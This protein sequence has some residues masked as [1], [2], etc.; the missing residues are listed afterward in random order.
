MNH[1]INLKP[2]DDTLKEYFELMK[3]NLLPKNSKYKHIVATIHII[4]IV[5]VSLFV[6]F[7]LLLPPRLQIYVIAA[8]VLLLLS[9]IVFGKCVLIILTNWIGDTDYDFFFPF[10]QHT[11]YVIVILLCF[12]SLVFYL[13]PN[14]SIF[15]ILM[16]LDKLFS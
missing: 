5:G 4:H 9:W 7:G 10:N 2:L 15:N 13:V 8:Y 3:K 16:C 11:L 14:V 1:N 12:I 6:I